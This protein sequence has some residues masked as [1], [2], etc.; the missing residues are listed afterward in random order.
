MDRQLTGK[1]P[2]FGKRGPGINPYR[3]L[4]LLILIAGGIWLALQIG[5]SPDDLV[6]PLYMPTP[7]PTRTAG[8]Y[9]QEAEAYFSAGKVD[10]PVEVDAIDAYRKALELEPDNAQGWAELSRLYTYSSSL[11][12]SPGSRFQA[13]V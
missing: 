7:T 13:R 9:L 5:T 3:I 6:K 4:V 1:R 11:L 2:T 8:S 10:D 12:S